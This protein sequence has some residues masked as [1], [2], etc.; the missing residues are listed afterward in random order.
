VTV[1]FTVVVPER[2]VVVNVPGV[3]A[4]EVAFVTVQ[5]SVEAPFGPT[6][7]GFAVKDEIPGKLEDF[8]VATTVLELADTL[9]TLSYAA[10]AYV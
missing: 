5:E 9:P 6:I 10:T 1:G 4:I 7:V 3:I 8:V 2:V